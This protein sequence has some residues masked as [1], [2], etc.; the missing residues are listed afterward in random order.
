MSKI[1]I[2]GAAGFIGSQLAHALW[3]E[4]NEVVLVDDF[5]YGLEDNLVFCDHDFR[6]EIIAVPNFCTSCVRKRRLTISIILRQLHLF[7]IVRSIREE[8]LL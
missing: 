6:D 5:S 3:Q 8:R 2:T 1:L 7:L 4:K